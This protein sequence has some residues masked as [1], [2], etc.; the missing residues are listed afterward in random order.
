VSAVL[1]ACSCLCDASVD[2]PEQRH[3][4][5]ASA[6]AWIDCRDETA[7][8]PPGA[9]GGL[10]AGEDSDSALPGLCLYLFGDPGAVARGTVSEL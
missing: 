3:R 10:A 7:P 1:S 2:R 9:V 4:T 6:L 8:N 5:R